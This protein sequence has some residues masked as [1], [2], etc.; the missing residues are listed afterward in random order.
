MLSLSVLFFCI[1]TPTLGDYTEDWST[2]IYVG[3]SPDVDATWDEALAYC[4]D[5]V[6]TTLASIHSDSDNEAAILAAS[7]AAYERSCGSRGR[8]WIGFNDLDIED[9]FVW[10]DGSS[11]IYTNWDDDPVAPNDFGTQDCAVIE[12]DETKWNDLDCTVARDTFVCNWPSSGISILY[13]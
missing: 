7:N 11:V 3:V 8:T 4:E 10:T 12:Q 1:F 5:V 9:T 13:S 6:G 2:G